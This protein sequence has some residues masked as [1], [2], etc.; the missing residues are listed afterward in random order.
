MKKELKTENETQPIVVRMSSAYTRVVGNISIDV[1]NTRQNANIPQKAKDLREKWVVLSK[2]GNRT[3]IV[4]KSSKKYDA[5]DI[6][7]AHE[8]VLKVKE[9]AKAEKKA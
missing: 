6:L 1:V 9:I 7:L 8:K 3:T 2:N 4:G 5:I